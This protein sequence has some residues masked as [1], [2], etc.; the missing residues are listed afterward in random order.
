MQKQKSIKGD[1][2]KKNFVYQ[3]SYRIL[4]IILPFITAPYIARVLG[5]VGTGI[6]SYV[7][8]V[9]YF[10]L[11]A[12]NLGISNY[13]NREIASSV[14]D[15]KKL[16][17]KFFGIYLC[18]ALICI[19]CIISYIIY[20]LFIADNYKTIFMW[21][22]IQLFAS[23]FDIS[24]FFSGIQKFKVTVTR[25]FIIRV[26]TIISIFVFIKEPSDVW[27]YLLINAIG[28]LVGQ[29]VVWT[30]MKQYITIVPIKAKDII[31]HIKPL[32]ILFVPIIA[33]SVYRY[34]DKIMVK[35]LSEVSELGWYE[36][37]EKIVELP[38]TLI[39][40]IGVVLLPKM[41]NIASSG[42][43]KEANKYFNL[44]M[45]YSMIFAFGLSAGLMGI[46]PVFAPVFFGIDFRP[47]GQLIPL[48][49]VTV[50]FLTISESIRSQFLVPNKKDNASIVATFSGAMV[51]LIVNFILIPVYGAKGAV[52]ATIIT[53]IIV[54]IIHILFTYKH[55]QYKSIFKTVFPFI[56]P[57]I[58]MVIVV[59][60][61][62]DILG[63]SVLTIVIQV[64][65]GGTLFVLSV[66]SILYIQKDSY[67]I[68]LIKTYGSKMGFRQL[69]NK[70]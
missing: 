30:Q 41:S 52:I 26:I 49:A 53:E 63:E 42:Q 62:G 23:L 22:S 34:M 33:M 12:A 69:K 21:Q 16:S 58:V 35:E 67:F 70:N 65:S 39:T 14:S 24:W 50:V 8:S 11:M 3:S 13:G 46:A 57:S 5:S 32:F 28:N 17:E 10:F 60:I 56:F 37:S 7:N 15:R 6:Y 25:N 19:I 38:L 47:C 27:K 61:I 4:S 64:I 1:S 54:A 45:K 2:L 18:H 9:M 43:V 48:L 59:R 36:N 66:G 44:S 40:T 29:I 31:S 20:V 68:S 55:L 51:N